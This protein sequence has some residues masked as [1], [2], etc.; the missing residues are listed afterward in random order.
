MKKVLRVKTL[1]AR[2]GFEPPTSRSWAWRATKL[3]HLAI[4]LADFHGTAY[5]QATTV[6]VAQRGGDKSSLRIGQQSC[7]QVERRSL[8]KHEKSHAVCLLTIRCESSNGH[9]TTTQVGH[10]HCFPYT[11]QL[12]RVVCYTGLIF[13]YHEIFGRSTVFI[14]FS[15]NHWNTHPPFS[16]VPPSVYSS[17][18]AYQQQYS[19]YP[20]RILNVTQRITEQM[21]RKLLRG[22]EWVKS[23]IYINV[24]PTP[25]FFPWGVGIRRYHQKLLVITGSNKNLSFLPKGYLFFIFQADSRTFS[26]ITWFA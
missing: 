13:L 1:G 22:F 7:A 19:T 17:S 15:W 25:T 10:P 5:F 23:L 8:C 16:P 21:I 3:L 2:E 20:Q 11:V 12:A 18:P 14:I 4:Y 26:A 9:P 24:R 6:S